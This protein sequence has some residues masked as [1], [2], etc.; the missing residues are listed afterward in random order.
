MPVLG[1][2]DR[3]AVVVVFRSQEDADNGARYGAL[4]L[5]SDGVL[6]R[7]VIQPLDLS[8]DVLFH[9][10]LV[11]M[12]L[13]VVSGGLVE[14]DIVVV[15]EGHERGDLNVLDGDA[16]QRNVVVLV[17]GQRVLVLAEQVGDLLVELVEGWVAN[18]DLSQFENGGSVVV[19]VFNFGSV[20]EELTSSGLEAAVVSAT[21][22]DT[23]LSFRLY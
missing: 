20:A 4:A 1:D 7:F 3:L 9:G 21:G 14:V 23:F 2:A 17:G 11:L 6:V 22:M 8:L 18:G 13:H 16:V 12:F 5:D 15:E 10:L 19:D